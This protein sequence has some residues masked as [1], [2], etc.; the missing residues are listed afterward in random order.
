MTD[1][2]LAAFAHRQFGCFTSDQARAAGFTPAAVKARL[3][4]GL[5]R[6]VHPG[7]YVATTTPVSRAVLASAARLRVGE[8]CLFS[9][10]TGARL[11]GIDVRHEDN[12]VWLRAGHT[13][14]ARSWLGVR[15]T[16]S[17]HPVT[18]VMAHGQ[19]CVPPARTVVDLSSALSERALAGLLYDVVRRKFVSADAVS[20][21]A[22]SVGGGLAG[23]KRL[24]KVLAT[25]DPQF[26]AMVEARVGDALVAAGF[27]YQPQ[28]EVWDGPFLLARL[29]LADES[30]AHGVEVD[31]FR[32][33]S[34]REAQAHDRRRDRRLQ[35]LGW[36]ISRFDASD[37]LDRLPAVVRDVAAVHNRLQ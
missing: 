9:N 8:D 32:Y 20:A 7:V 21:E 26:E 2:R 22:E 18:P 16:R 23:L 28:V 3:R 35:A 25:F 31:G 14:G 11:L 24:R 33:H 37:A 29:D 10:F 12:D 15:V 34:S 36:T 17:R 30:V 4:A 13:S 6:S 5:W 19:P 1:Q 27:A